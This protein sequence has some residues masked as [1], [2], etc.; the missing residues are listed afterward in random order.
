[1]YEV[2]VKR[3]TLKGLRKMPEQIQMK[4]ANLVEDLRDKGPIRKE[5]PNFG[6]L[7]PDAY[8]CHLSH[9]WVACWLC[10]KNSRIIEVYYAGSRE[11]APY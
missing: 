1:M 6:K 7:G 10:Q 11:N 8:H 2:I 9:H 4:M 3:R 5:W